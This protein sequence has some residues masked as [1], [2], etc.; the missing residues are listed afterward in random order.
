MKQGL[1][2]KINFGEG[3]IKNLDVQEFKNVLVILGTE[4]S[5]RI[6]ETIRPLLKKAKLHFH[7]NI[8]ANLYDHEVYSAMNA[9]SGNKIDLILSVGSDAVMDCG[10]LVA[11]LLSHGGFL[12]DYLPGG[13]MGAVCIGNRMIPHITVPTMPS[14]GVEISAM[15]YFRHG[16]GGHVQTISSSHLVP[17]AT[18][19]DPT[20][21]V[22]MPPELWAIRGF[23]CFVTALGAFVSTKSNEISDAY[24]ISALESYITHARKLPHDTDNIY[25]IKHACTASM[26]AFL[27]ANYSELG[28]AHSVAR[29]LISHFGIRRGVALAMV[30][31]IICE[32]LY[33]KNPK[34]FDQVAKMLGGKGGSGIA[35]RR[36]MDKLVSDL[37]IALPKN[38]IDEK[39]IQDIYKRLEL[40]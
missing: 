25:Y 30:N 12:H 34:R 18:Y 24:A 23:D 37:G 27:A 13:A 21:M 5:Q 31:G 19:I 6:F 8:T 20:L 10:R 33:K 7:I 22:G 35:I 38:L 4:H 11:L 26:N 2:T 28:P 17:T 15:S 3:I 1:A 36:E 14:A 16:H 9:V 40:C 32:K 39:G 29:V